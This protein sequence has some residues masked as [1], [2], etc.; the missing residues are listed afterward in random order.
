[1][2]LLKEPE[3]IGSAVKLERSAHGRCQYPCLTLN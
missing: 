3:V 2:L 1:M